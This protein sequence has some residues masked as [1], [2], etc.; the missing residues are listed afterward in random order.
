MNYILILIC[1]FQNTFY[2]CSLLRR[3]GFKDHNEVYKL[4]ECG[5]MKVKYK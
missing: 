1:D 4:K 2:I 3:A 5:R